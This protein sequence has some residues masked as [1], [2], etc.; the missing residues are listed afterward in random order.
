MGIFLGWTAFG[1]LF[2]FAVY[3]EVRTHGHSAPRI[4][5]Y[6]LL[7]WNRRAAVTPVV[8]W[9]ARRVPLA[10]VTPR[11][12][13]LHTSAAVIAGVIHGVWWTALSVW[14]RPFDA[15]G[16]QVFWP[17]VVSPVRSACSSR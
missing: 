14:M 3:W 2:S 4:V 9:L 7:V 5:G 11:A 16:L 8:A 10:P 13:A 17:E 12:V 1:L 6:T 15:M